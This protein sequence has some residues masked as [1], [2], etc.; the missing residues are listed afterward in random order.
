M[1]K[2][3]YAAL[4]AAIL[5]RVKDR[6]AVTFCEIA[7]HRPA[8]AESEKLASAEFE[9]APAWRIVDRRLQHLRKSG[10]IKYQRKPEGWVIA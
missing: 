8:E 1:T 5:D 4:D 7:H 2:H 9:K 10:Q 6:G 3:D